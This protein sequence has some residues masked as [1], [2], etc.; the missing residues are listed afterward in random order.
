MNLTAT[1]SNSESS[2]RVPPVPWGWGDMLVAIVL[3]ALS[4]LALNLI[5]LAASVL[6]GIP[7]RENSQ[8]LTVFLV[9][10]DLVIV[11]TAWL[12]TVVRYRV[13]WDRLGLRAYLVPLG[14]SLSLGLLLLS[15]V[16]RFVYG[17][18]ALALGMR[19]QQQEVLSRLDMQGLGFLLT[20]VAAAVVAPVAEEI[21]FR[22]FLY[23]GLRG[24]IGV[25]G[26]MLASTMFFTALHLSVELFIP[27]F[28]LG[29]FLALLYESTGSLY[30]GI[31]LHAANNALSLI[32]LFILQSSGFLPDSLASIL[33]L[34]H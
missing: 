10:Q 12:F 18:I 15:Y 21:F 6:L 25:I 31:F 24:R 13:G 19:I 14:C 33:F 1:N 9:I 29:L 5:G 28:V 3:A 26:A 16:I 4:L 7:L 17:L 8:V 11:A 23:S 27:I 32:L 2:T 30:P 34:F 20:L 22:G